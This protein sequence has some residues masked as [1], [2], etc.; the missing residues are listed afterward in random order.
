ME[1]F[2][3]LLTQQQTM[4][5]YWKTIL[6]LAGKAGTVSSTF[7]F[8]RSSIYMATAKRDRP[9]SSNTKKAASTSEVARVTTQTIDIQQA[10]RARA[11]ELYQQRGGG[12]GQ[13]C[14]D[15]FRAESEVLSHFGARG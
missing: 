11:Y 8:C 6:E 9:K 1:K 14:E 2:F 10:I 5:L 4:S 12:H 13:D 15:W 3:H 7:I